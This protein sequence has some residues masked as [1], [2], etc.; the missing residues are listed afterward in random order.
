MGQHCPRSC[1]QPFIA[2]QCPKLFI[3]DGVGWHSAQDG[4][5][6]LCYGAVDI[7]FVE[8]DRGYTHLRGQPC[9]EG[10][11]GWHNRAGNHGQADGKT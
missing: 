4:A 11:Q 8:G 5:A 10:K 1:F 7:Y 2:R 6:Q 3:T 9:R